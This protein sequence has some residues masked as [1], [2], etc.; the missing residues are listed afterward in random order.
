ML[1]ERNGLEHGG[2]DLPSPGRLSSLAWSCDSELL[3]V[4]LRPA[5]ADLD[6][7][8]QAGNSGASAGAAGDSRGQA[9]NR[10]VGP[11]PRQED[12]CSS[13]Q[14]GNPKAGPGQD[15]WRVQVWHRRNWHWY[16][17]HERRYPDEGSKVSGHGRWLE[18]FVTRRFD[19]TT[20]Q[21]DFFPHLPS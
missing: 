21:N 20:G 10:D 5:E 13:G 14:G 16:L 12:A 6:S 8:R 1:Y 18:I 2:F 3:A 9:G 17:K 15:C 7:S 19:T 11:V 4:V